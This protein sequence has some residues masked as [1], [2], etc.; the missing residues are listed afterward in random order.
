MSFE[1]VGF[2][3]FAVLSVLP[4]VPLLSVA[5]RLLK[6]QRVAL[7][8][9]AASFLFTVGIYAA[10]SIDAF[11]I[12]PNWPR[13]DTIEIKANVQQPLT[14]LHLS[15]LHLEPTPARRDR[16]LADRLAEL[17]PDIIV[18]TGDIH[19]LDSFRRQPLQRMLG[20]IRPRLGVFTC[21]GFDNVR[22]L[23]EA[24]P[25]VRVL[26][27]EGVVIEDGGTKIGVC[28]LQETRGRD[29]AYASISDAPFKL[30]INPTP[31]LADEAAQNGADLYLCGHTHGG[32]VRIPLWGAIITNSDSGK[33]YEAGLYRNGKTCIYTSRGFGLEP[34]PAPQVRFFCRPQITLIKVVPK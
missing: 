22:I 13:L 9:I 29:A 5:G 26:K 3:I 30:V 18:L 16:W 32:Q 8:K 6:R 10:V 12:E 24:L 25:G 15:D 17:E 34:K 11:L 2:I 31:D 1:R 28:G 19:Q 33:K 27:N 4:V 7:W 21:I 14:I 23:R 20:N